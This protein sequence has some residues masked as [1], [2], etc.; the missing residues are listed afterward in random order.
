LYERGGKKTF[1]AG[2][3]LSSGKNK[4]VA[5]NWKLKILPT[6]ATERWAAGCRGEA[7]GER[8]IVSGKGRGTRSRK[9]HTGWGKEVH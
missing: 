1:E 6:L 2:R 7:G 3:A 4:F 9:D 8:W 5:P